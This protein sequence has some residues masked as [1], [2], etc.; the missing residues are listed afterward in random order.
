MYSSDYGFASFEASR[1]AATLGTIDLGFMPLK[2]RQRPGRSGLRRGMSS[3]APTEDR[4]LCKIEAGVATLTLNRPKRLNAIDHGPGSLHDELVQTLERLD[5]HD[6]VRCSI[7]TGAGRAFSSGGD[8]SKTAGL[9]SAQD[10]YWFHRV[11]A[12]ENER[13]RR[14]RKPTIGAINGICYGAALIMAASFDFLVAA[15]SAKIGLLETRFGGTG[16]NVLAYHVGPQWAKFLALSG[17]ILSAARARDIGLVLEVCPDEELAP[18][19]QDLGRRIASLPP[20]GV[21]MNR[22]VV[23]AALDHMGWRSQDDLAVALNSIATA[24]AP[25]ARAANGRLFSE[26]RE[27]GW[28]LYKAAR[29]EPFKQPWLTSDGPI[30]RA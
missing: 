28:A 20:R 16:V 3:P 12:E 5:R 1:S 30:P 4:L 9:T 14:L 15:E 10:W 29:D 27:E 19:V 13:L 24:E 25:H 17:E 23:N 7:I 22:Q 6:D 2:P 18:R 26:L 8:L 21:E 11:E